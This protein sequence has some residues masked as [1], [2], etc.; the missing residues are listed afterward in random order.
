MNE[1]LALLILSNYSCLAF[2]IDNAIVG[3]VH[4]LC[5][6]FFSACCCTALCIFLCL[7]L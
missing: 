5:E 3:W 1:W 7:R 6:L 4:G 2:N